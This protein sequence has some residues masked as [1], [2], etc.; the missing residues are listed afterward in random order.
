MSFI[1]DRDFD[2]SQTE[3]GGA[4]EVEVAE[5]IEVSKAARRKSAARSC[6]QEDGARLGSRSQRHGTPSR[7]QIQ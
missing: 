4:E 1:A 7:R 2:H 3:L 5:G 6:T